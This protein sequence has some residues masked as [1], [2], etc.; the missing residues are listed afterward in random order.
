MADRATWAKRVAEWRTSGRT[1]ADF[2]AGKPFAASTLKWWSCQ[3]G[4]A[5]TRAADEIA[6][7]RVVRVHPPMAVTARSVVVE[8]GGARVIVESGFDRD[9][10]AAVLDVLASRGC[11]A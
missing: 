10:L 4:P 9:T 8:V 5:R 11:A 1:A 3:L 6:V 2:C 7:A